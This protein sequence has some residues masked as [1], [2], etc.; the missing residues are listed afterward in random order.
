MFSV[1]YFLRIWISPK[2]L[3][4]IFSFWGLIDLLSALPTYVSL[5]IG[6]AHY[7]LVLRIFRLL[8]VFRILKLV[9]FNTEANILIRSLKASS[10]K[11]SVFLFTVFTIVI[12]LGTTMYVVESEKTGFTSIPQSFYW[13]IITITTVGY[14]DVVPH[15]VLGKFISSIAMII[16]YAI[17]AVPTGIVT[18]ELAKANEESLQCKSCESKNKKEANYCYNCGNKFLIKE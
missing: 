6:G 9:R 3:R 18:V 13:A 14:G 8:R 11:I 5:I 17:I 12:I 4:Y 16:G 2:P 15:T 10:Y 1:E 7:F